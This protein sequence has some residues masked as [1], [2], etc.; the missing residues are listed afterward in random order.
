LIVV[1]V[2]AGG[3]MFMSGFLVG[4]RAAAQPGT[5]IAE[6][7]NFQPFWDTWSKVTTRYAGGTVDRQALIRGAIKGMVDALDDPYSA[8]LTPDEY[9]QSVQD[10]S[11][12]FEGIGAEIG[13]RSGAGQPIDCTTLG[14]DCRLVIVSPIDGSPAQKAGLKAGDVVA[15]VDGTNLDGLTVDAARDKIR[16]KKGT[17]VVLTIVRGTAPSTDIKVVRDVFVSKEV[18][19]KD[20][21]GGTVGYLKVT[22]FSDHASDAFQTALQADLKAGMTRIVLDLR[23]NPGGYVTAARAI[24]SQ[25]IKDGPLFYEEDASGKQE[26]TDAT[27]NG[28]ATSDAIK[29]VVLLDKG[30][31]SASEIV[32]GALQDRGRATIVGETSYGKGTVQQWIELQD[33]AALKLTVAKWLTPDKHWIHHVGI[34]PDVPVATP[35][36][37]A[38]NADPALDKAVQI[39]TGATA[40]ARPPVARAA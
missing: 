6:E 21:A 29:L 3:A 14:P 1:S 7:D 10:L 9:R 33:G 12:Q 25:F 32:A 16:G 34:I 30:S 40:S 19:D 11:G 26:G 18:I 36:G 35:S 39:L 8:Y 37:G 28:I 15:A 20:L 4:Q 17:E 22:G 38:A 5:P 31:A 2:L 24:A 27:G 13:T 23:G